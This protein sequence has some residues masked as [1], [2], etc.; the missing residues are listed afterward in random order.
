MTAV[1]GPPSRHCLL[2]TREGQVVLK[3][4]DPA[5]VAR[6]QKAGYAR[7]YLPNNGE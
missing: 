6:S 5:R 3:I 4:P 1:L 2:T 7:A